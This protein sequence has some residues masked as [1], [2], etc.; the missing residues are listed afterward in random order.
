[1]Y[2]ISFLTW[3][4][5][6]ETSISADENNNEKLG[7]TT[8]KNRNCGHQQKSLIFI[9]MFLVVV[10]ESAEKFYSCYKY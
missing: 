3:T 5:I 8:D 6:W 2:C 1:M 9:K 7:L 4:L 10:P